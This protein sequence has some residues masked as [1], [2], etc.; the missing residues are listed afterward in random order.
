MHILSPI[1]PKR[2][3]VDTDY[4][5]SNIQ[6]LV[7][8]GANDGQ[9]RD[10]YAAL[11]LR[12]LWIEALPAV[13]DQLARNLEGYEDNEAVCALP[14]DVAGQVTRFNVASNGGASSSILDFG[15]HSE[16]WPWV[17][18]ES[19]I[20]LTSTTLDT[21]APPRAPAGGWDAMV[22]DVQ[23][24][25]L[26]VL[27]GAEE[28]LKSVRYV[29]VEAAD[30]QAYQGQPSVEDIVLFLQRRGFTL[31]RKNPVAEHLEGGRYWELLFERSGN[32]VIAN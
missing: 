10:I 26:K 4:F 12:V 18:F 8:V 1:L 16:V 11:G 6:S 27:K 25:E 20:Q 17:K 9:E 29:R 2:L 22:M 30:F 28:T 32:G 14:L 3:E 7:H 13:Y 5:L 21:I 23:G 24:A 31:A 19:Q 15:L